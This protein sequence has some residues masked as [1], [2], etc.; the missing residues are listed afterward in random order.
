MWQKHSHAKD[1]TSMQS[2]LFS[3]EY[4]DEKENS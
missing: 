3:C 4:P 1:I 2:F